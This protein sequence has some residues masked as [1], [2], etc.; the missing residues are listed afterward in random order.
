MKVTRELDIKPVIPA[1]TSPPR[2]GPACPILLAVAH[3]PV[4]F[5][6]S[7]PLTI[8]KKKRPEVP[9]VYVLTSGHFRYFLAM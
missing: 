9:E 6:R 4:I 3:N 5:T 7:T 8:S 1:D 2:R